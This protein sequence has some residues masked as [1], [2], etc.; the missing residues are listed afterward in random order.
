MNKETLAKSHCRPCAKGEPPLSSD[1][2]QELLKTLDTGWLLNTNG[3]LY[4]QFKFPD[5]KS[6]LVFTNKVGEVAEAENHHPDILLQWGKV[7]I[8][9]YT[10]SIGGLSLNDFILAA[11]ID[12][13]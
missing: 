11:Q 7:G 13:V 1:K 2:V 6:A 3:H 10:H 12:T 9:L 8:A 5:F 4:K